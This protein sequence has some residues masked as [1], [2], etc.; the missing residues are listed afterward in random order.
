MAVSPQQ[1]ILNRNKAKKLNSDKLTIK[2]RLFVDAYLTHR[3]GVRAAREAG[4]QG[5]DNTLRVVAQENLTKPAITS[6]ISQY[7]EPILKKA[8]MSANDVLEHLSDIASSEWRDHLQVRYKDGEIIDATLKLGD[9]VKALEIMAKY[10]GLLQADRQNQN[11]ATVK[12][13]KY[14]T[15][16]EFLRDALIKGGHEVY[17]PLI[18]A[19]LLDVYSDAAEVLPDLFASLESTEASGG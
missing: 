6:L 12:R 17:E 1:G 3:N 2:Q 9:K 7:L 18:L 13:Q 8:R 5:N 4:Y 15:C 19:G 10:H 16:M 14:L 11:E